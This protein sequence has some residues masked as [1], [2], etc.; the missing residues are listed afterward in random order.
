M[1]KRE[2]NKKFLKKKMPST[3][4]EPFFTKAESK[5]KVNPWKIVLIVMIGSLSAALI[6]GIAFIII[7]STGI[8]QSYLE[9]LN[10]HQPIR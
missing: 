4:I 7:F 6:V 9:Y 5:K 3:K 1:K 2:K 10:D 8:F